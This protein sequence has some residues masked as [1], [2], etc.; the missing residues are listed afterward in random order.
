MSRITVPMPT[1]GRAPSHSPPDMR[2]APGYGL[3]RGL[4][5]FS[6]GLGL[7]EIFAPHVVAKW[8]GV[9]HPALLRAF[10]MR[11]VASGIGILSSD[12]PAGWM[13]SRVAGDAIDL[14]A[15]GE[16]LAEARPGS[17]RYQRALVAAAAVAG[18]MTIDV[19]CSAG[20]SAAAKLEG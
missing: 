7:M 17:E 11:E 13:W 16:T 3:A 5:W 19:V 15:I 1:R 12:R 14:A 10:G 8:T 4:G 18:V 2:Y 6:I 9:R 20:L